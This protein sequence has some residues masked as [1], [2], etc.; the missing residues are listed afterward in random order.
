MELKFKKFR[1]DRISM[2]TNNQSKDTKELLKQ[3]RIKKLQKKRGAGAVNPKIEEF[4]VDVIYG[5]K[6]ASNHLDKLPKEQRTASL[7]FLESALN[8]LAFDDRERFIERI[9]SVLNEITKSNIW[10]VEQVSI[11][12]AI[13]ALTREKNRCAARLEMAEK[14]GLSATTIDKHIGEYA[15]SPYHKKRQDEL[16]LMR[17]R[18]LSRCYLLGTGGDMKAARLF[19]EATAY[20]GTKASVH[21]QQNN[22][23]QVNNL[24]ITEEQINQLPEDKQQ[25]MKDILAMLAKRSGIQIPNN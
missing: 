23:I 10:E 3:E 15:Q 1:K 24:T 21:N 13:D 9:E 18:L 17:E 2:K 14:T 5:E 19:L 6:W 8:L 16:G 12:N 20:P 7:K 4:I 22:F 11:E 25:Q